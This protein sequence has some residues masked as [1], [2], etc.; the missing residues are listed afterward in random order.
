MTTGSVSDTQ[1]S[2]CPF[3]F[4]EPEVVQFVQEMFSHSSKKS[5]GQGARES[6]LCCT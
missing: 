1:R 2:D 5:I 6:G 4:K 3:K